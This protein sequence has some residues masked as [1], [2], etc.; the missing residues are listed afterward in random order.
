MKNAAAQL[1]AALYARISTREGHQHLDNQLSLLRE[2]AHRMNWTVAGEYTDQQ[3]GAGARRAALDEL[4]RD[5]ARRKFDLVAVY[6]LS[7]FTRDG[8]A[9]AFFLIARL[10]GSKVEF[11]SITEEHFRT[12]GAVGEIFIA[13]AAH[14]AKAERT[15]IQNRIRAGQQRAR[16]A[17]RHLGRPPKLV[18]RVKVD[19]MRKQGKSMRE[20][21]QAF[22][23]GR[24][25]LYRKHA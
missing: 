3:S 25:T 1:R 18:D 7:R 21:A 8:P 14:I 5:A 17:G 9:A 13:L 2:Y 19:R 23:V 11:W 6:D 12:T 24:S 4:M 20:I 16:R 15:T 22:G 10:A